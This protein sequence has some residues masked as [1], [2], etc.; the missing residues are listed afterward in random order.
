VAVRSAILATAWLLVNK[1]YILE[2]GTYKECMEMDKKVQRE[3]LTQFTIET[4]T[5]DG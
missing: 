3:N 2:I 1:C 5:T 4:K